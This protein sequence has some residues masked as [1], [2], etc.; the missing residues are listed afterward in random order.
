MR[1]GENHVRL[2][3]LHS[4][5]NIDKGCHGM[6]SSVHF[7][8]QAKTLLPRPVSHSQPEINL[9]ADALSDLQRKFEA[10]DPDVEIC[11]ILKLLEV[12]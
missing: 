3:A 1:H 2:Q 7:G 4:T 6:H 10:Y 12:T 8:P 9:M 5:E 11:P